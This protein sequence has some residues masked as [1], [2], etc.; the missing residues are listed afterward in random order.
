MPTTPL[1]RSDDGGKTFTNVLK[2]QVHADNHTM[3][4]NPKDSNHLIL[5]NDGGM[6]TL[7]HVEIDD[8]Q[9]YFVQAKV[10]FMP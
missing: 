5:G 6:Y 7:F 2:G 10:K 9:D 3:W 1:S 4:I 8:S